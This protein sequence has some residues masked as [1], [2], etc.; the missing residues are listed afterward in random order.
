MLD[1]VVNIATSSAF[2]ATSAA[3]ANYVPR[4]T[5]KLVKLQA[6]KR[7]QLIKRRLSLNN[8]PQFFIASLAQKSLKR[9]R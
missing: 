5:D 7:E 1:K 9:L 2:L 8:I 4:Y 3:S 6:Q